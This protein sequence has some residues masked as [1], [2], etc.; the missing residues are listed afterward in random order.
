MSPKNDK[1]ARK[2][3]PI[4]PTIAGFRPRQFA[5]SGIV[6]ALMALT[7]VPIESIADPP[8][9]RSPFP[10]LRFQNRSKGHDAVKN[11]GN[12]LP[13]V[14]KHYRMSPERFAEILQTDRH[15]WLD[16]TG[17]LLFVDE[18]PPPP[19]NNTTVAP[20]GTVAAAAPFPV[21]DTFL[22]H[23]KP[24]SQRVIYLD[25]NG[26]TTTGSA[27][28][29]GTITAAAFNMDS[30]PTTFSATELE[31][32]QYIWQRVADDYAAF[33][34]DVTTQEPSADALNRTSST[35]QVYG[36]RA[37]ITNSSIG[38]CTSCGGVA[39]VGVFD[40]Y[41][42]TTPA[43]YQPAWV[44]YDKLGAGNEKY[45]AE[46]VSHEV[47]H[48]L[49]LSHD[50]TSTVGYYQGHGSGITGWAPIM[51]V[52]Y[53]QNLVQWS[54]GEYPDANNPEDDFAVIQSNGASLKPDDFGSSMATASPL[55]GSASTGVF[56]VSQTGLIERYTDLD[57]FSFATNGG[58][59]Q[60]TVTPGARSPNLDA[61]IEL[62]D[63]AGNSLALVNPPDTLDATLN[64][65]VPAG[66]YYLKVD[67]VGKGDLM[68]GYSDY[69]SVGQ[70]QLT[71][72]LAASTAIAPIAAATATPASGYAPLDV[73]FSSDG[74]TDPDGVIVGYNWNFGDGTSSTT[75]NPQHTYTSAAN[76]SAVLT[77]TD[78][79]GLTNAKALTIAVTQNP[80]ANTL[81]IEN[82]GL[83]YKLSGRYYT[84]SAAVTVNNYV[85][86]PVSGAKV[87]GK[88]SG[89]TTTNTKNATTATTGIATF[90]SKST[91]KRGTCTFT[92]TGVT[93]SGKTYDASQNSETKDS[94]TY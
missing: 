47:G 9:H 69:A 38:V 11:L 54:L 28:N 58:A 85:N 23:S 20:A 5:L 66:T 6:M 84:C 76:Y 10:S 1:P 35:D 40:W 49:G 62:L 32:I 57:Y 61:S 17:R 4:N 92:V 45:V 21:G 52:G 31:R 87:S 88:W 67:G 65:T 81:H 83:S 77:V 93:K 44:L 30:D 26:Y 75:P 80:T 13:D 71:G 73:G 59:L 70:Y 68:T 24:G 94:L 79:Q 50:G 60:L 39:Y 64:A 78:A 18:F 36:T 51:G 33:D 14:A 8:D 46:A 12:K 72:T 16:K 2:Y 22:L 89:V 53:Y 42:A 19:A 41:S 63:A 90:T 29:S 43:Y 25:F 48:N 34:V 27:W 56:T 55:G 7:V 86:T 74:S 15:A 91:T 37:V 3:S 82:I